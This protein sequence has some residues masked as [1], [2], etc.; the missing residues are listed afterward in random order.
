M[1]SVFLFHAIRAGLDMGIVNPGLLQVYSEIQSD[2]LQLT[3]DVVLNRRKDATERLV[4]FAEGLKNEGKKEEK[5]DDWRSLPVLDRIKHSLK[6]GLDE[7][8]EHDI[9]EARLLFTRSIEMI[10]GP[11]MG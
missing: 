5:L 8:I 1:H 2:L 4:K 11:L 7:F 6:R 9:N 3:E 10:E